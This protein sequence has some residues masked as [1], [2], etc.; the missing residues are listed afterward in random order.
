MATATKLGRRSVRG[1]VL[2]FDPDI[3]HCGWAIVNNYIPTEVGLICLNGPKKDWPGGYEATEQMCIRVQELLSTRF[4]WSD[5][6][7]VEGQHVYR[8]HAE[9]ANDL[10]LVATVTGAAV[11][12]LAGQK[13]IRLDIVDP[14]EWKGTVRK[15]IMFKRILR[16]ANIQFQQE[17]NNGPLEIF[18]GD[19]WPDPPKS[20]RDQE[21]A[22]DALGLALFAA[23]ILHEDQVGFME[24][25]DPPQAFPSKL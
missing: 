20:R 7:A 11:A 1:R 23:G 8:G 19:I 18:W 16:A 17:K 22:I 24:L 2:G 9:R 3:H 15:D 12:T 13:D 25:N 21:H 14:R 5:A 10:L 4:F 6:A